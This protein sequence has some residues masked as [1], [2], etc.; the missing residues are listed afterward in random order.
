[1]LKT[2]LISL[3]IIFFFV[4]ACLNSTTPGSN[5]EQSQ[6]QQLDK[7]G[8]YLTD[9]VLP[10]EEVQNVWLKINEIL[11]ISEEATVVISDEPTVVDLLSLVGTEI[12]VGEIPA[13]TYGQL[14]LEISD[15][16]IT[17]NGESYPLKVSS[18]SLKYPLQGFYVRPGGSIVLDFD[19]SRSIKFTGSATS[20]EHQQA[21]RQYHM[22]P[23]IHV[24]YGHLYDITGRVIDR[25][26]G[27]PHVL[28]ALFETGQASPTAVTLTHKGS[29]NWQ[30]GE[31]KFCKV[32]PGQYTLKIYTEWRSSE[33]PNH[34]LSTPVATEI[35]VNVNNQNV[36]LGNITIR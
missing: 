17:I 23:V 27:V 21:H 24:R 28:L 14:R 33:D 8:V 34:I 4:A 30:E 3:I 29:A 1:M 18:G 35:S 2:F 16:T 15:A 25:D 26:R 22:T 6:D 36:D 12:R 10:I 9:A 7:I 11:L 32:Q 13:R 31:F 19:L 20:S 5:G